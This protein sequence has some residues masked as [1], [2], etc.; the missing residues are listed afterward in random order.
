MTSNSAYRSRIITLARFAGKVGG[1]DGKKIN[2]E[3][4]ATSVLQ[5]EE[6]GADDAELAR[7][8]AFHDKQAAK[9]N[10]ALKGEGTAKGIGWEGNGRRNGTSCVL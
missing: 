1:K 3:A 4:A 6:A 8:R 2:M 7:L 5:A 9:H 10:K